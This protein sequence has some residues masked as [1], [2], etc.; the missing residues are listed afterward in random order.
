[1]KLICWLFCLFLTFTFFGAGCSNRESKEPKTLRQSS[2]VVADKT[3]VLAT[4]AAEENPQSLAPPSG[5]GIHPSPANNFNFIFSER[6]GGVAYVLEKDGMS[7][8]VH[9]GAVGKPYKT[10]GDVAL[11]PDG[12]R[13]AYGAIVDGKWRMVMDGMEGAPFNAV[14]LPRFSPD[15]S[16]LAYQG[17]SGERWYLVVDGTQNKGTE[18][19]YLT[20]EFSGDSSRIVYLDDVDD[21]NR[22]R[23]VVSDLA[24]AKQTVIGT[25]VSLMRSNTDKSRIAAISTL[26]GKQRVFDFDFDRPDSVK[27]GLPYDTVQNLAFSPDG[28]SLAYSAERAGKR[29]LVIDDKEMVLPDGVVSG[30]PVIHPDKKTVGILISANNTVFLQQLSLGGGNKETGYV[31]AEGLVYSG[32]GRFHAYAAAKDENW[33]VV[34]NGK[35]GP[36]F[37]RVV[38]PKFTPDGKF[39]VYRAR[40]DGK[41]FVV[42]AD[43]TGRTVKTHPAYEQVFD[44]VFTVDGKSVA[45]GVK[46]GQKLIWKVEK[47]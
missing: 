27:K 4:I 19:R 40:K 35:E 31:A 25:G 1:M 39:L 16:H 29:L 24:F 30:L 43:T 33:F 37:D 38:T 5:L 13:I 11:S 46:D 45:Y 42:V 9:S 44:V 6:G 20:H 12:K 21:N 2:S 7:R 10:V 36:V 28:L 34:V 17:M 22:G 8:V 41:R 47:L 23:L 15:G 18:K 26:D 32:D 14:R 3:T